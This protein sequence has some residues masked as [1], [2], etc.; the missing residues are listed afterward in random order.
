MKALRILIFAILLTGLNS[1]Q[2]F[3]QNHGF[4]IG[5]LIGE[6]TGISMKGWLS[7]RTAIDAGLAWSFVEERSLHFHADYLW[8]FLHRIDNHDEIPLYYGIGG[9]IKIK[10][11]QD[12]RIGMRMV[13]GIGYMFE[14]APFDL[15]LEIAP[16][17]DLLPSTKMSANAG[18]GARFFFH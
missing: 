11:D 17:L 8:H 1:T 15:F 12:A 13:F 9:R 7:S 10:G 3:S 14:D 6:P 16:I 18:F 5:I 4:G 2:T